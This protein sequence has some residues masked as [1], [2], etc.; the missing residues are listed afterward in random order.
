MGPRYRVQPYGV[1]TEKWE[2]TKNVEWEVKFTLEKILPQ[3]SVRR[4][5]QKVRDRGLLVKIKRYPVSIKK[6][7]KSYTIKIKIKTEKGP[8]TFELLLSF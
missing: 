1:G 7:N 5:R 8:L 6:I 2:R 4:F 3:E